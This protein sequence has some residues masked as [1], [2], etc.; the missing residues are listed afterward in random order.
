[1]LL[2][3]LIRDGGFVDAA[4]APYLRSYFHPAMLPS[5]Y[6]CG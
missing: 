5:R 2:L 4:N 1:L 6:L 3:F